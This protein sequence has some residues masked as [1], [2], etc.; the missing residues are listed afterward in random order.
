MLPRVTHVDLERIGSGR[1]CP[2]RAHLSNGGQRERSRSHPPELDVRVSPHSSLQGTGCYHQPRV[3]WTTWWHWAS[4]G[5]GCRKRCSG[6]F[7]RGGEFPA[8]SLP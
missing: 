4:I 2:Y 6:G 1:M 3:L 5:A 7:G 8:R